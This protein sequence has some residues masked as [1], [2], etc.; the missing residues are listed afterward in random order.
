MRR[1]AFAAALGVLA[2]LGAGVAGPAQAYPESDL[3]YVIPFNAGGESDVTARL[4]EPAF[5]EITG[6]GFIIQYLVGAGGATAWTQLNAMPADGS[7]IM[8]VN[9]PHLWLQP[10]QGKVGYQTDDI[11]IVRLFQLT[12]FALIV[13]G[14]S[15][16]ETVEQFID[17]AKKAPGAITIGGT[18]THSA[19]HVAQAFFDQ[20][21]GIKTT[22]IPFT[23]TAA[24]TAALLGKQVRAQ[25]AYPTVAVEQQ[26]AVRMLA[27][28]MEE[29][30]PLFPDVPTFKEKGFDFVDGAYR[31]VAVPKET[32]EDIKKKL[33]D[34]FGQINAQEAFAKNMREGGYVLIDVGYDEVG[35]F[36]AEGGEKYRE[37]A[38]LL[39][40][41]E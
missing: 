30:H 33:S 24:S 5:R 35:A 3:T 21:A 16:I 4:Q 31:G 37:I 41:V 7:T 11:A 10:M 40:L 36:M 32:P 20:A 14:D 6:Q 1:R 26:D 34:I 2:A 39:G 29:R 28:A 13:P 18:G 19:P 8:G 12:P 15:P 9:L 27:V 23:G 17:E 25:W 22:Y 38:R